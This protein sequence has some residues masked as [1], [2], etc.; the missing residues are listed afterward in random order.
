MHIQKYINQ[1]KYNIFNFGTVPDNFASAIEHIISN[2]TMQDLCA[3]DM[4]LAKH[5]TNDILDFINDT[6][7][8]IKMSVD[9]I[10]FEKEQTYIDSFKQTTKEKF[11]DSWKKILPYVQKQNRFESNTLKTYYEEF[12]N[13]LFPQNN[14][15]NKISFE[16]LKGLFTKKWEGLLIQK[17]LKW[18]LEIIDEQRKIFC[19]ELYKKIEQL[20]KL[21]KMLA[22]FTG[23]LGRLWD[24]SKGR[25]QKVN[26]D[27][28]KKYA[29]ILEKDKSLQELAEMLGR[30]HQAEKEY[31]EEIFKDLVIKPDWKVE[32]AS[33]AELVGIHESDD[34]SSMLPAEAALLADETMEMLF[35]KKFTEKKLQTYEYQEKILA[36]KEEEIHKN[37][38]KAK[39]KGPFI[40]CVDSSGSMHDIPET[41]AKTLCFVI[42]K[43]AVRENRKCYL[44]SFSS[45]KEINTIELTDLKYNLE[46]LI[47]FLSMSFYGGSDPNTPMY[48]ASKI[49]S[50]KDYEKADFIM[51]SDF[52][53]PDFDD[54]SKEIINTAK[55]KKTIFHCIEIGK[56]GNKE[57]IKNFNNNWEYNFNDNGWVLKMVRDINNMNNIHNN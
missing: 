17:I 53:M 42:L 16:N 1:M 45:E 55:E 46:K 15:K 57:L 44:I 27:I 49:L 9:S 56:S 10:E 32:H 3:K 11:D 6:Q 21:Q 35:Y 52:E 36:E 23:E 7:R 8:Q 31:E 41:I 39:T 48:E 4:G 26:F 19:E 13:S 51:V 2:E 25:W 30:M 20:K 12:N 43:M 29:E 28:L 34:I 18:E 14:K 33:K 5:V 37:K 40:F 54:K 38:Q 47:E 24:M 50:T 22:P